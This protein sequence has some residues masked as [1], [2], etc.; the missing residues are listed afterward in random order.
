MNL[1][2]V[3][4]GYDQMR[5]RHIL[6]GHADAVLADPD[7][8]GLRPDGAEVYSKDGLAVVVKDGKII[9]AYRHGKE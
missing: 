2:I 4:H 6:P 3:A 7:W 1:P 9:T 5:Q 8:H